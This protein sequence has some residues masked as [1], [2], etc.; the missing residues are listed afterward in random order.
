MILL[1]LYEQMALTAKVL[2]QTIRNLFII[3]QQ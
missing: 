3:V 2:F 1:K